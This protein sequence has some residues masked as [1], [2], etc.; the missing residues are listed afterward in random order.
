MDLND[1]VRFLMSLNKELRRI[2]QKQILETWQ[3]LSTS[4]MSRKWNALLQ[5]PTPFTK[6]IKSSRKRFTFILLLQ[7][8]GLITTLNAMILSGT[9]TIQ[10]KRRRNYH[11]LLGVFRLNAFYFTDASCWLNLFC[12]RKSCFIQMRSLISG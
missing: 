7:I 5:N 8:L 6:S 12:Q 11:L 3:S 10:L 9:N 4:Q 2:T 1:W